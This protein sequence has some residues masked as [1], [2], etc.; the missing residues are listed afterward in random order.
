MTKLCFSTNEKLA[1][2]PLSSTNLR[3]RFTQATVGCASLR[4]YSVLFEKERRLPAVAHRAKAGQTTNGRPARLVLNCDFCDYL[5]D[6]D[7]W[8]HSN[9]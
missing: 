4:H 9:Q 1:S 5:M 2:N 7:F 8:D 3:F 6:Y